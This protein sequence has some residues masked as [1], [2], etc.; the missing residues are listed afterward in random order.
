MAL[1]KKFQLRQLS[2]T[3]P[4]RC[5]VAEHLTQFFE[6]DISSRHIFAQEHQVC[7]PAVA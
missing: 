1:T 5:L 2:G 7:I 4:K 3:S 6:L